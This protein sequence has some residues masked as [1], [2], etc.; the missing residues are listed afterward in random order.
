[1]SILLVPGLAS[2]PRIYAAVIP[3]LWRRGPVTVANHS[4]RETHHAAN[5]GHLPQVEQ[6][7]ASSDALV[8]WLRI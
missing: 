2:S 1:M 7:Q 4:G 5:C 3:A 8:E 6:A